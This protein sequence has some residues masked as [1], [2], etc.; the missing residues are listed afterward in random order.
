MVRRFTRFARHRA[1]AG[2][3]LMKHFL[4]RAAAVAVS[5]GLPLGPAAAQDQALPTTTLACEDFKKQPDGNW[6]VVNEKPFKLGTATVSINAGTLV[7]PG[8][9]MLLGTDL[10]RLLEAKCHG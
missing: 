4:I 10:Y 5:A 6:V 2:N 1:P 9:V 7:K 3:L 8:S